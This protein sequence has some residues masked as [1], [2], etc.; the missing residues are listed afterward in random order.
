MGAYQ[1]SIYLY[2]LKSMDL[3]SKEVQAGMGLNPIKEVS[4]PETLALPKVRLTPS[5]L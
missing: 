4:P 1:G 5:N 2:A 3:L